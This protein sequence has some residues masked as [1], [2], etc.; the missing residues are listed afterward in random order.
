MYKRELPSTFFV[1]LSHSPLNPSTPQHHQINSSYEKFYCTTDEVEPML[2]NLDCAKACGPDK[3][4]ARMLKSIAS[5]IVPSVFFICS[6]PCGKLPDQWNFQW[7]FPFQH[8]PTGLN[9]VITGLYHCYAYLENFIMYK[10]ILEHLVVYNFELST[11][12]WG[13]RSNHSTV[14]ALLSVTHDWHATL[15]RGQEVC[16]IFFD[17]QKA[18]DS[19]P[20]RPLLEYLQ[21]NS[22]ILRWLT[23]YLTERRQFVVVIGAKSTLSPVLSGMPQGSILG[24]LLFLIYIDDLSHITFS[25]SPRLHMFADDVLLYQVIDSPEDFVSVQES[26]NCVYNWSWQNAVT[27]NGNKCKY[28]VISRKKVSFKP[29]SPLY[30]GGQLLEC[31]SSYKYLGVHISSDLSWSQHTQHVCMKAVK[32]IGLLYRNYYQHL[33]DTMLFQLYMSLVRPHLEYAA[34]IWSPSQSDKLLLEKVQKFAL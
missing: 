16:A 33:P 26:I 34:A 3:I 7:L 11:R 1:M 25:G 13:F 22:V 19:V 27:L 23:D 32:M 12:Q 28:M 21:L 17:Y 29:S 20:H 18:F 9:Q 15:E 24:P 2:R 30:L 5:S 10:V 14:S 4:S 6:I 31:V 8:L